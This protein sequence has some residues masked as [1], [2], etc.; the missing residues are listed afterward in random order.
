MIDNPGT[1]GGEVYLTVNEVADRLRISRW[2]VYE[3]IRSR[4]LE[5]FC[6]GRCRRVKASAVETL[7][8][9]LMKDAA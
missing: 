1:A 3:L 8:D 5:S 7:I 9:R 4:E 6:V 2:K